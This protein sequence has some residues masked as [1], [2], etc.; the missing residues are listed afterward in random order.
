MIK[1]DTA[2]DLGYV[3]NNGT[4]PLEPS[5]MHFGLLVYTGK[6]SKLLTDHLITG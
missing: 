4:R 5:R 3:Q 1:C 6:A 2:D